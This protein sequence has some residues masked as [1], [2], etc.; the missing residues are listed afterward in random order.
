MKQQ[1]QQQQQQPA[2][3]LESSSKHVAKTQSTRRVE[4]HVP[5]SDPV[6]VLNDSLE[7][8]ELEMPAGLLWDEQPDW[9]SYHDNDATTVV[10]LEGAATLREDTLAA[11]RMRHQDMLDAEAEYDEYCE[12]MH[13]QSIQ[14]LF[15]QEVPGT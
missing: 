9:D 14:K 12:L 6:A 4:F 10:S 7:D 15:D 11:V 3:P 5:E 1:Q 2:L 8:D 13:Q